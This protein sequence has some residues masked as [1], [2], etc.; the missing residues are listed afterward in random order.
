MVVG[1]AIVVSPHLFAA[2]STLASLIA[3]QFGEATG[4]N[5]AA[6]IEVALILFFIALIVNVFARVLLWRMSRGKTRL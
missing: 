1:N 3:S 6:I 4:I 2:G 5:Q